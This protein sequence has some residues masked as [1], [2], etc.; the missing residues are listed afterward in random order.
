MTQ[1]TRAERIKSPE[2][3][4]FIGENLRQYRIN[5]GYT[6]KDV[7]IMTDIQITTLVD[8]EKGEVTNI[9]Y[10]VEYA[11]AVKYPLA[12]LRQAKIKMQ[13]KNTLSKESQERI[14][15]TREIR[16]HIIN[17]GFLSEEKTSKDIQEELERLK[18]IPKG[19]VETKEIAGVMRNMIADDVIKKGSKVGN[20][21]RYILN[22]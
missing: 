18:A 6:L 9:D 3:R 12:T 2:Y 15:L 17:T 4:K 5:E 19:S 7:N 14:K 1:K 8:L 13:P 16:K 20:K 10:Y 22:K 11:K 21:N